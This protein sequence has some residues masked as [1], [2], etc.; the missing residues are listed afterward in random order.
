ML[1]SGLGAAAGTLRCRDQGLLL[2]LWASGRRLISS[3]TRASTLAGITLFI[4]Q[5]GSALADPQSLSNSADGDSGTDLRYAA[6]YNGLDLTRPEKAYVEIRQEDR[7]SG[8]TRSVDA[9]A[10]LFRGGGAVA[11]GA[12]WKFGWLSEI[13]LINETNVTSMPPT[14]SG[15]FGIGDTVFQGVL[16]RPINDR[17]GYGF[18]A[19][20]VAPTAEDS[21]GTG[22]WQ[23]MPGFG[24]RYSFLEVGNDTYFV[25]KLRYAISFGGDPSRRNRNEPQIAPTLNIGLPDRW[26]VTLYPSYDIRFNYGDPVSGQTGRLFLPF[27]AA[28]GRKVTDK[29]VIMWEIAAPIVKD[30]PVY[31]F[32]TELR[33]T[34]DF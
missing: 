28:I 2:D 21:L 7:T 10:L 4:A 15:E 31:N 13:A 17:W 24:I 1:G 5:I 33:L 29:A 23:I 20:L 12:E 8:T 14:S 3:S 25:P 19:R 30:Y 6:D 27:D 11:L 16:S 9:Q 26:F 34:I 22:R 32:K 18:G